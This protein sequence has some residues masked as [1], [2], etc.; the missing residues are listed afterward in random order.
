MSTPPEGSGGSLGG[1]IDD[2]AG[3]ASTV[4][5]AG[6]SVGVGSLGAAMDAVSFG[7]AGAAADKAEML[8]EALPYIRRFWGKV[9]VVKYGGNAL[10]A[11]DGS[12]TPVSEADA[13]AA[14]AQD[15]VLMR[16]VGMLPVVVH[17]GG[18]Q[19]GDLMARLGKKSEFRDGFRVTDA[20]TLEIARMVLVGKVNREIGSSINVHGPLAVGL[21]GEDANLITATARSVDLGFVGNVDVV[22]PTLLHRLL[23]QGLI[24]VVATIAADAQGQAYNVNAD[25][26]AGAVA[27]ALTAEKLV[28]LTD[29]TGLRAVPEDPTTLLRNVTVEQLDAMVTSGAATS[30]MVPKVEACA[31]AVRGGVGHAH[32]LDGRVPHALL[33]EVF[34]DQGVGTMIGLEIDERDESQSKPSKEQSVGGVMAAG[35]LPGIRTPM[36]PEIPPKGSFP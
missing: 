21:S 26:V 34:T 22:D 29:V 17:G 15:V 19:I 36:T 1:A 6:S 24:P 5:N 12:S 4:V 35:G 11:K 31:R 18:P 32:I 16:S 10:V 20:E 3:G 28:F 33:L 25:T 9:V 13:L 23:A 30:G 14:F 27:V 8:V 2:T 7:D